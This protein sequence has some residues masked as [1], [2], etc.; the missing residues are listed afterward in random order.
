MPRNYR[1]L[2]YY[3]AFFGN[4]NSSISCMSDSNT[5][6]SEHTKRHNYVKGSL[7]PTTWKRKGRKFSMNLFIKEQPKGNDLLLSFS[8]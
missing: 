6:Q 7:H 1:N 2:H 3:E 4:N 5:F 8:S